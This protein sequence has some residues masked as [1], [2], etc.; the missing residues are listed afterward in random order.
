MDCHLF[1]SLKTNVTKEMSRVFFS[2]LLLLCSTSIFAKTPSDVY[3]Q[4]E[5]IISDIN[6]IRAHQNITV[7][8]R[9]P[10][11]QVAKTPLHV[12]SKGLELF[13]KVERYKAMLN[14]SSASI[15]LLP[16]SKVSP[17]SV[18][19]LLQDIRKELA[20]IKQS[21]G[22]TN[23]A[24]IELV[25]GKTPSDVYE[26]AWKASFLMDGLVG[27]LNPTYVYRN[28]ERAIVALKNIANKINKPVTLPAIQPKQGKKPVDANIEAFKALYL[29]LD[30]QRQLN[31]PTAR[32]ASFPSGS[33]TP[34]DVYDTTNS[35]LTELTRI[36]VVLNLPAIKQ[37]NLSSQKI[38]PNNVIENLELVQSLINQM[39]K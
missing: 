21:L 22:I 19:E 3:Q 9:N 30:L 32:V 38:T 35:L 8:A 2:I 18:F 36:N 37:I 5:F 6:A 27:G 7:S 29:V 20:T 39:T 17:D 15:P 1:I 23:T 31:I 14:L 12:Y 25:L 33:I 10:G 13:E 11:V 4:T 26:N 28:T 16:V 34:S 24:S